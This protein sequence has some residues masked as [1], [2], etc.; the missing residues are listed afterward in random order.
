MSIFQPHHLTLQSDDGE[1]VT[2]N[3]DKLDNGKLSRPDSVRL[4]S[5]TYTN[6]LVTFTE[7]DKTFT[8]RIVPY[9]NTDW[10]HLAYSYFTVS[11]DF[12][13]NKRYTASTLVFEMN[14]KVQ[15]MAAITHNGNTY[16]P[17]DYISFNIYPDQGLVEMNIKDAYYMTVL[18]NKKLGFPKEQVFY[19]PKY[20]AW[21]DDATAQTVFPT[22]AEIQN[23]EYKSFSDYL[24][25]LSPT[26]VIHVE[27]SLCDGIDLITNMERSSQKILHSFGVGTYYGNVSP[28]ENKTGGPVYISPKE[29][30]SVSMR[31]LDKDRNVIDFRGVGWTC[32]LELTYPEN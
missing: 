4:A 22:P 30:T 13:T 6:T 19:H 25:Q 18:Q 1:S 17:S 29:H 32:V 3:S 16:L 24:I 8:V 12:L 23:T 10:I 27:C 14:A 28:Y 9:D 2:L 31:I 21:R 20:I 5:L 26:D 15:A 7:A 11:F